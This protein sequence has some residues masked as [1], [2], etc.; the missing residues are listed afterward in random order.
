VI[1]IVTIFE[2]KHQPFLELAI[3]IPA[4]FAEHD[5]QS[6][7]KLIETNNFGT[8]IS[9]RDER[10]FAT[11]LPFIYD[12]AGARLLGHMARS[13]PH[14]QSLANSTREAL[15]IFQG[16]NTYISPSL[17]SDPGVPTW[18]Y[19]TV[20]VYGRFRVLEGAN[21]HRRVLELLTEQHEAVREEPWKA[22]FYASMVQQMMRATVALEIII[23]EQQGKFKLSQNRS[24]ADREK[25][26]DGLR[27]KATK[28][29]LV[30]FR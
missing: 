2:I 10:P 9:A 28:T 11:H 1:P 21:D 19:A 7:Q 25:V 16:P 5:L 15:V 18:N 4:H 29:P 20:H 24:A 8:L 12:A 23:S 17:Y 27:P 30:S 3:Y 13:N 22:D 26:I 6:L 14:W